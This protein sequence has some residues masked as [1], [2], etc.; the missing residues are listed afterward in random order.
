MRAAV[1]GG[2]AY[3]MGTKARE[4]QDAE[5]L[6]KLPQLQEQR[7][8]TEAEFDEQKRKTLGS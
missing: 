3:R 5:Q 6:G 2:A 7:T 8:L 1:I 4:G